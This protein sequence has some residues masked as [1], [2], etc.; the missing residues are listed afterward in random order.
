MQPLRAFS[1]LSTGCQYHVQAEAADAKAAKAAADKKA[2]SGSSRPNAGAAAATAAAAGATA[3]TAGT[4]ASV[5]ADNSGT[6][7]AMTMASSFHAKPWCQTVLDPNATS[8][9]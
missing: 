1:W 2:G 7:K 3:A 6:L 4:A 5:A 9:H 8:F